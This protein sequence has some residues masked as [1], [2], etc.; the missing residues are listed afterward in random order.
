MQQVSQ[1]LMHALV[2]FC[3]SGLPVIN[4][5]TICDQT[6]SIHFLHGILFCMPSI[7]FCGHF[8]QRWRLTRSMEINCESSSPL[9][10]QDGL[11]WQQQILLHVVNDFQL[12]FAN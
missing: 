3:Q 1:S 11:G 8:S 9:Q 5:R 7:F 2:L 4:C 10:V 6:C 12:H